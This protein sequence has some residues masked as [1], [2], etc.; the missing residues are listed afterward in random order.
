[1]NRHH[2]LNKLRT[3]LLDDHRIRSEVKCIDHNWV[4]FICWYA[5]EYARNFERSRLRK[6][7]PKGY[8]ST[9]AKIA[10]VYVIVVSKTFTDKEIT[11]AP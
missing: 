1:M 8:G 5:E 9:I 6:I 4:M 7:I 11:A 2:P 10:G 3:L